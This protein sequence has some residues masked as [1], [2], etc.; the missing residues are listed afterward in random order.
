MDAAKWKPNLKIKQLVLHSEPRLNQWEGKAGLVWR[1][2]A[3]TTDKE[4]GAA[5]CINPNQVIDLT[6]YL[7]D[8]VL[9][10]ETSQKANGGCCAW[11][12]RQRG[13]PT[14]PVVGLSDW[15]AISLVEAAVQAVQQLVWCCV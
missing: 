4:I 2:A 3:R 7:R 12:I 15:S 9:T 5:D 6:R 10:A 14:L 1:V 11:G 8:G 13:T